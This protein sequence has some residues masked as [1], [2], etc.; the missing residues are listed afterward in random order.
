MTDDSASDK[1]V[2]QIYIRATPEQVWQVLWDVPR[3]VACVPGCVEAREV[4][5]VTRGVR[6]EPRVAEQRG[7]QDRRV[8]LLGRPHLVDV[9]GVE[10][11]GPVEAGHQVLK[12]VVV[13]A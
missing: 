7:V 2:F 4:E 9:L 5:H 11:R 1:L 10:I 13:Q 3:M 8:D 12:R 6:V